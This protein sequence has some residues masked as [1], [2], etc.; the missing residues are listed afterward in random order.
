MIQLLYPIILA[1]K[2]FIYSYYCTNDIFFFWV[3]VTCNNALY[4][5]MLIFKYKNNIININ[6]IMISLE[7]GI[8]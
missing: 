5:K 4:L 8:F 1:S 2:L 6:D 3:G 7:G